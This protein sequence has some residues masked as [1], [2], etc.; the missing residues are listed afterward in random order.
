MFSACEDGLSD[1]YPSGRY[2]F[3][4]VLGE[5]LLEGACI[6][7]S[8]ERR[9]SN[10]GTRCSPLCRVPAPSNPERSHHTLSNGCGGASFIS[11]SHSQFGTIR[12]QHRYND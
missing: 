2:N 11:S 3:F 10:A 8:E 4:L 9:S 12:P 1:L 5:L 7:D 6:D